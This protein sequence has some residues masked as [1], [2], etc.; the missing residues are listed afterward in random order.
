MEEL[1]ISQAPVLELTIE[2][3]GTAEI[4]VGMT[5]PGP[6]G[7]P[8]V[9]ADFTA[10]QL[11]DLTGPQGIQGPAGADG[12]DAT[13]TRAIAFY[14]DGVLTADTKLCSIIAPFAMTVIEVRVA[15]DVAPT[16]ANL[17]ADVNKNGTT[18]YTTQGN[19]PTI[20]ATETSATATDPDVTSI[21]LGDIISVDLDQVGSTIAGE[22]LMVTIICEV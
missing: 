14:V 22:N 10:Q 17:I 13:T 2:Q 8:F 7:E 16:G 1:N 11:I 4:E 3:Q 18:M 6:K 21:A 20:I 9:Y 12:I 15:V 19:R 5:T